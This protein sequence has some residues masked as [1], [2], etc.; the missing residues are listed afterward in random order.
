MK[1]MKKILISIP[2][3]LHGDLFKE[4]RADHRSTSNYI[5]NVLLDRKKGK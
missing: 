2:E 4:A 5:L 1:P 3:D